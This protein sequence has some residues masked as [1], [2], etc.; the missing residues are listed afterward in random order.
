MNTATATVFTRTGLAILGV[1][2]AAMTLTGCVAESTTAGGSAATAS[3]PGAQS[4]GLTTPPAM[5]TLPA[6]P[7]SAAAPTTRAAGGAA[8]GAPAVPAVPAAPAATPSTCPADDAM[9]VHIS[10]TGVDAATGLRDFTAELAEIQCGAGVDDD[11]QF[12]TVGQP[13]VYDVSTA[14]T[15]NLVGTDNTPYAVSWTQFNNSG[16]SEY[17]GYYGIDFSDSGLVTVIN[18]YF[19]P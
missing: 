7:G 4:A 1:G 15:F 18:Q 10:A 6:A 14:A 3:Q 5:L 19:H 2:L 17:G 13:L 11:R 12:V 16:I 9:F 8:T